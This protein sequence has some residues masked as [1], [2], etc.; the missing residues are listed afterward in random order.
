LTV[1]YSAYGCNDPNGEIISYEWDLDGNGS[2]ETDS[3]AE[4]GY[5]FYVYTKPR[6]NTITVKVTNEQ[7]KSKTASV[8]V[9]V[10]H[11]ASSSVDYWTIFDDSKVRR[12]DILLTEND[13]ETMW[14]DPPSKHQVK[15]DA[16]I[17]GER[18]ENVGFRMRGQFSL[19]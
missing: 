12:L 14:V 9:H 2:F 19:R 8:G 1:F 5:A 7:G 17:F 18:L 3:T 4:G 15:V 10:L 13:W 6:D 11:P 16:I